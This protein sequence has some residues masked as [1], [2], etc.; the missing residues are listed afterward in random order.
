MVFQHGRLYGSSGDEALLVACILQSELGDK[1]S[2]N[3]SVPDDYRCLM[4]HGKKGEAKALDQWNVLRGLSPSDC[5]K[6]FIEQAARLD[7]F[8]I[9]P[10]PVK[11]DENQQVFLGYNHFGIIAFLGSKKI[12]HLDWAH[13]LKMSYEGRTFLVHYVRESKKNT[14]GLKCSTGKAAKHLWRNALETKIFF[15]APTSKNLSAISNGSTIFSRASRVRF[16]GHVAREAME[17][18]LNL[19]RP[20]VSFQR[21]A[22]VQKPD[23]EVYEGVVAT[24]AL[25]RRASLFP[26]PKGD[27]PP[28]LDGAA[29]DSVK[30]PPEIPAFKDVVPAEPHSQVTFCSR[31]LGW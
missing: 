29:G 27:L 25:H 4:K 21:A 7:T 8:G 3:A 28:E 19:H 15:T 20:N 1:T 9:D 10:H 18:S 22:F 26:I 31:L 24:P 2:S 6:R 16:S 13:I 30:V 5:E 11:N 23:T 14:R 17:Q 12:M